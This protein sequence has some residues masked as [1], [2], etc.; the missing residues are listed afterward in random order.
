VIF[1]AALRADAYWA[2]VWALCILTIPA[3]GALALSLEQSD[4]VFSTRY[5]ELVGPEPGPRAQLV[6][7][8]NV[9]LFSLGLVVT[10]VRYALAS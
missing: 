10:I 9:V 2:G 7:K 5:I 1:F 6:S 8:F 3:G 4:V